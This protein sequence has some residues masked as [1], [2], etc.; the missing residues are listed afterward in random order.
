[1]SPELRWQAAVKDS[2]CV[3]QQ[4]GQTAGQR[5]AEME[6]SERSNRRPTHPRSH[7]QARSVYLLHFHPAPLHHLTHRHLA[8]VQEPYWNIVFTSAADAF[9]FHL[10][11]PDE[12]M[13]FLSEPLLRSEGQKLWCLN[14]SFC[15]FCSFFC[16]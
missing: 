2:T 11:A 4:P 8:S 9:Y 14:Q 7:E 15:H 1:M 12:W 16:Y 10:E 3:P 5:T 13:A 6:V